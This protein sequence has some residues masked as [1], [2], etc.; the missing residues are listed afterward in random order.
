[1]KK[2]IGWTLM[3][4]GC[5]AAIYISNITGY[6]GLGILVLAL[7]ICVVQGGFGIFSPPTEALTT[8]A[9]FFVS[10]IIG[11]GAA[12]AAGGD[13]SVFLFVTIVLFLAWL[14]YRKRRR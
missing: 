7:T 3:L 4:L 14:I 2:V 10:V 11:L 13:T 5:W 6:I 1:M 12:I 9:G 8:V